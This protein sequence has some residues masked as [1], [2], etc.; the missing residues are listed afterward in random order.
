VRLLNRTTRRISLT[1]EGETYLAHATR[2][3]AEHPRD[4]RRG[5]AAA[6]RRPRACCA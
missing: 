5:V 6:A 4:G 2:I 1:S 3:L